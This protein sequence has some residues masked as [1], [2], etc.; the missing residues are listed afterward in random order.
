[1]FFVYCNDSIAVKP[2]PTFA[3]YLAVRSYWYYTN[4][5]DTVHNINYDTTIFLTPLQTFEAAKEPRVEIWPN[6]VRNNL[7]ISIV[8]EN[9]TVSI[10]NLYGMLI[11][12]E[13]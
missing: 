9:Q 4:P 12:N 5:P 1:M 11:K 3:N 10:Y 8:D 2:I 7:F 13:K 6:P